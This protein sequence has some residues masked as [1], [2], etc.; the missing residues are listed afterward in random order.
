MTVLSTIIRSASGV[1]DAIDAPTIEYGGGIEVDVECIFQPG[2]DE[3][4]IQFV[5]WN[6]EM[7]PVIDVLGPMIRRFP[8]SPGP[9]RKA[10]IRATL[11]SLQLNSGRFSLSVVLL[12]PDGKTVHCRL[13]RAAQF[14]VR[15][16]SGSACHFTML[17]DWETITA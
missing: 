9:A 11:A 16:N 2:C 13:D 17:A 6:Q 14:L 4:T 15:S 8:I 10:K 12:S 7:L 3:A 5:I 1:D